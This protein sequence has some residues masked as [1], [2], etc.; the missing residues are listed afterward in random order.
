MI[1]KYGAKAIAVNINS[2]SRETRIT[3]SGPR[4]KQKARTGTPTKS[5]F[6]GSLSNLQK[7]FSWAP[8]N[9]GEKA[10]PKEPHRKRKSSGLIA[11]AKVAWEAMTGIQEDHGTCSGDGQDR[12]PSVSIAEEWMLTGDPKKDDA[13]RSLHRYDSAPDIILFK[14]QSGIGSHLSYLSVLP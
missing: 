8:R 13:V 3:V 7:A 9:T 14:V 4:H 5:S 6:T 1:L 12:L 10:A 2:P 11:P